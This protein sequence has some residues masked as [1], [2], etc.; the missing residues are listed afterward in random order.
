MPKPRSLRGPSKPKT[1]RIN[2]SGDSPQDNRPK[3]AFFFLV[4]AARHAHKVGTVRTKS[5]VP[6]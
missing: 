2:D 1:R 4:S 3:D 5:R 6:L